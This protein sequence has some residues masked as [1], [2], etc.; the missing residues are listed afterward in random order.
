[1]DSSRQ[2]LLIALISTAETQLQRSRLRRRREHLTRG[3]RVNNDSY[4]RPRRKRQEDVLKC[5]YRGFIFLFMFFMRRYKK[6]AGDFFIFFA[7]FK[8]EATLPH[9]SLLFTGN[10]INQNP[11]CTQKPIYTPIFTHH[12]RS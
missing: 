7:R 2:Y 9:S 11:P 12:M 4:S 6:I 5:Y 3:K 8:Y 10:H 1:M